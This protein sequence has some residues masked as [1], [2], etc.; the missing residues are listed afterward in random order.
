MAYSYAGDAQFSYQAVIVN[1][2][3]FGYND[4]CTNL[5]IQYVG[6]KQTL[7]NKYSYIQQLVTVYP[8]TPMY[9]MLHLVGLMGYNQ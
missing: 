6:Y 5:L 9:N 4:Y 7:T 3:S 2:Q 1:N 8:D